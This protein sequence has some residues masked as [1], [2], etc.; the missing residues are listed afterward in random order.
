MNAGKSTSL[1]QSNYNYLERGM[2]TILF[3]SNIDTRYG[4][5]KITSRIGLNA[6]AN[7][8]DIDFDMYAYVEMQLAKTPNIGCV[9]VDEVHFFTK[10]QIC[11]LCRIVDY[12]D[13][14]VLA[15]GIRTDFQ[16]EPFEGSLYLLTWADELIEIKTICHCGHKATM[17]MRIDASGNKIEDG[18]QVQVGGNELYTSTCRAHFREGRS[19]IPFSE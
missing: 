15:Y 10:K 16:A 13:L 12:L 17:N 8:I 18:A 6:D 14:P 9:F 7:V 3:A 5:R 2:K 11:E 4:Q 1:L 19:G